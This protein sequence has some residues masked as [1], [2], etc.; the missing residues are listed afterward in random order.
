MLYAYKL[1]LF[2]VSF[3][4]RKQCSTHSLTFYS[5]ITI[6]HVLFSLRYF[7]KTLI[8]VIYLYK[9]ILF[10][11]LFEP[12]KYSWLNLNTFLLSKVKKKKSF[13]RKVMKLRSHWCEITFRIPVAKVTGSEKFIAILSVNALNKLYLFNKSGISQMDSCTIKVKFSFP[14]SSKFCLVS[15]VFRYKTKENL[16][17]LRC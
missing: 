5:K 1:N 3:I 13:L 15:Q 4:K 7:L 14:R 10:N 9:F 12:K 8:S 17:P 2:Y 16:I 11:K 6:H